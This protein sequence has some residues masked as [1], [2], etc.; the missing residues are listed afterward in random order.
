MASF[1][2]SVQMKY[3]LMLEDEFSLNITNP[4]KLAE[5]NGLVAKSKDAYH[6]SHDV[7]QAA[8]Y[9]LI[10]ERDRRNNHI[11]YG[12]FFAK[13]AQESTDD[14]LL[15]VAVNQINLGGVNA[16][17][18]DELI[19]MADHNVR[20]GRKA[21]DMSD[22]YSAF[23]LFKH[24]I[25]FIRA[26]PGFWH[27]HYQ[28]SLNLFKLACQAALLTGNLSVARS[29]E[30][31]MLY[32]DTLNVT[33][34]QLSALVVET[35]YAEALDFG[36]SVLSQL[37]EAIPTNLLENEIGQMISQTQA[38]IRGIGEDDILNHRIM[39]NTKKMMAMRILGQLQVIAFSVRPSLNPLMSMRMVQLTMLHGISPS[40]SSGFCYFGTYLGHLG[41]IHVGHRFAQLGRSIAM[42]LNARQEMGAVL[43]VLGENKSIVYCRTFIGRS[44]IIL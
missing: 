24:A 30:C 44:R 32:E 23:S 19:F 10:G 20:A 4:M 34:A 13:L 2:A 9:D 8:S 16:V 11:T 5:A 39:T 26:V 29:L 15:F 28:F 3:L 33:F 17:P 40:A 41:S 27:S 25:D 1:G 6:F 31:K 7:I 37:G 22:F 43:C 21:M 35:K 38:L 14:E 36:L 12:R 42:K 18:Q